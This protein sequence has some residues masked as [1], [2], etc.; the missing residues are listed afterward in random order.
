MRRTGR[1]KQRKRYSQTAANNQGHEERAN[2]DVYQIMKRVYAIA[3][4]SN[5]SATLV[6]GPKPQVVRALCD[7]ETAD[8]PDEGGDDGK[9]G[10]DGE[11][12]APTKGVEEDE[13]EDA[14]LEEEQEEEEE[15][16]ADAAGAVDGVV[17]RRWAG[18]LEVGV[19]VVIGGIGGVADGF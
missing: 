12:C 13:R 17:E 19:G 5:G 9:V 15:D 6:A 10:G 4:R 7:L 11:M 2:A 14:G 3:T 16:V 8:G 1:K 18:E